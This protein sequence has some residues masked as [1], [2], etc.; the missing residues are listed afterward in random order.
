MNDDAEA[1][2]N[3]L[4]WFEEYYDTPPLTPERL[5]SIL[6]WFGENGWGWS[7]RPMPHIP[8]FVRASAGLSP[9]E[10]LLR[11]PEVGL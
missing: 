7:A 6:E 4:E 8:N 10:P 11:E 9:E 5:D 1:W 3:Y 2:N